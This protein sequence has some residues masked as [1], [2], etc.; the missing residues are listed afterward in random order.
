MPWRRE[1]ATTYGIKALYHFIPIFIALTSIGT[2]N[3]NVKNRAIKLK[4]VL[5][6]PVTLTQKPKNLPAYS[7]NA[8]I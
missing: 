8:P 7:K 2:V 3:L 6:S 1:I 5:E 4:A